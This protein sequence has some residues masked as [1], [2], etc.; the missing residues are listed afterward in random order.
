MKSSTKQLFTIDLYNRPGVH[1][2][3]I[4]LESLVADIQFIA[5][6]CFDEMPSYQAMIGT[7]EALSD[8]LITLARD[9]DQNAVGFCSMVFLP[10]EGVGDVLHLG[11][12]CV[13]PV[14][15][16]NR[17]TH[18]LVKKAIAGYM[19]KQNPFGKVWISNCASVMSSLGNVAMHF[20]NV[21]PSPFL[22]KKPG[23]THVMIAQAIDRYYRGKMYVLPDAVLDLDDF[24]F[25]GSV[26]DTVFHKDK[27]DVQYYHRKGYL[28]QF[29]AHLLNFE[30]GDEVL[31]I[32]YFRMASVLKYYLRQYK[33]KK[34][35]RIEG[36]AIEAY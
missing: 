24:V 19:I 32:G 23:K 7:R 25:R 8:K 3:E 26:K 18:L 22:K 29:Y 16:K 2:P 17:L 9:E 27:S 14:A 10:I 34:L 11:L 12:T 33:M 30:Q 13:S 21:Y 15:R 31:Q 4:E 20:E 1:L 36:P 6:Q 28:N 35:N 5:G